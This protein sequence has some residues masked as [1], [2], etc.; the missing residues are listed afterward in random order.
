MSRWLVEDGEAVAAG[1]LVVEVETDKATVEI[2]APVAGVLRIVAAEGAI[3]AVDGVLAELEPALASRADEERNDGVAAAPAAAAAD[4]GAGGRRPASA[5][6][7]IAS[8]AAR[9]LARERGVE[10]ASLQG[11]GSRRPDR[12]AGPR[13]DAGRERQRDGPPTTVSVRPSSRTSPPAGSR[14]P[15]STSAASSLRTG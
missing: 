4:G 2:E 8:P 6:G 14:S 13:R 15:T 3:V 9:R 10:L 12:G 1:Q 11:T 7:P 5:S